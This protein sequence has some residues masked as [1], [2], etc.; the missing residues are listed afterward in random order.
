MTDEKIFAAFETKN[1]ALW[2]RTPQR[3][4]HR[5][6]RSE[7]FSMGRWRRCSTPV[8]ARSAGSWSAAGGHSQ[9]VT[10]RGSGS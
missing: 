1:A 10:A 3:L 9:N 5:L 8:R 4:T 6:D 2:G 7:L